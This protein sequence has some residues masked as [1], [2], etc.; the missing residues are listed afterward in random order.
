MGFFSV[1]NQDALHSINFYKGNYPAKYGGRLSSVLDIGMREGNVHRW[2]V[3]GGI[4]TTS[5]R[6]TAQG[7]LVPDKSSLIIS[8]RRTYADLFLK[9]SA[10]DYTRQTS[11][12]F[13][14]LNAKFNYKISN[15]DRIYFSG[16]FGRDLNKIRSLQYSIDWGNTTGTFRWNHVFGDKIFSNLSLIA[17]NYDYLIDLPQVELPFEWRSKIR[18]YSL[19][20]DFSH[21]ITPAI[22]LQ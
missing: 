12:F 22:E 2:Q 5:A 16:Y 7:P 19:K 14:D 9:L 10:D 11:L 13:Y 3:A 1:F 8:A 21:Y 20:Y 15:R 4:G 6:I 18:D 17:S